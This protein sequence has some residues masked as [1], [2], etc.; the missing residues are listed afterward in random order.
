MQ[1]SIPI[2]N[3]TYQ[4]YKD[5]I[6]LNTNLPRRWR[7]GLGSSLENSILTTIENLIMAKKAPTTLKPAYLI[8]A[9]NQL[10]IATLKLRL[11]LEFD[12]VNNTKIFQTQGKLQEIGRMLG[13]WL[14]AAQSN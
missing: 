9:D 2:I 8:K 13:G 4:I 3:K 11:L 7:Y 1:S 10:E 5:I 14:K 6:D 12:L